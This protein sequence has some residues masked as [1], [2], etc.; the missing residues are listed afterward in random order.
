VHFG[1]KHSE[2]DELLE[3]IEVR[4]EQ[5]ASRSSSSFPT[6]RVGRK[7]ENFVQSVLFVDQHN[8]V[9][10]KSHQVALNRFSD[11]HPIEIEQEFQPAEDLWRETEASRGRLLRE[12]DDEYTKEVWGGKWKKYRVIELEGSSLNWNGDDEGNHAGTPTVLSSSKKILEV[13]ADLAIGKGSMHHLEPKSP[14]KKKHKPKVDYDVYP[15]TIELPPKQGDQNIFQTPELK[16][17]DMSGALLSIK[18]RKDQDEKHS[19]NMTNWTTD[20][21][22]ATYLN[23]ATEDN[24]DGVPLVH[25]AFDQ[26]R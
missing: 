20:D 7:L 14:K 13:A 25:D 21:T 23:W 10:G 11:L 16:D 22:F 24:P 4:E 17:P 3:R 15:T 5:E 8:S 26:V 1:R 9:A 2:E 18:K 19:K 6:Y 12:L